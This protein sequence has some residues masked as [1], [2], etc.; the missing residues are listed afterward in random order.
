[1]PNAAAEVG[2]ISQ[3]LNSGRHTTT[4]TRWY[5]IDEARTSA[6]IDSPGFQE[7]GMRHIEAQ[8]LALLMPD[9]RAHVGECRFYNCTHRQ[10]PGCGVRAALERGEI[11]PGRYR[12][13][14]EIHEELTQ[15][16]RW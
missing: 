13:Y 4:T 15:P 5:W 9:L 2:E 8:Q 14:D 7:F 12:I 3:A 6:L 10:E 16:P 1:V 11:S